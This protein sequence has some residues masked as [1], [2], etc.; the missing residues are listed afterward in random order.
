MDAATA[1]DNGFS[2]GDHVRVLLRGP[3]QEFELVGIF[4]FGDRDDFGAVTFAAFDLQTAQQVFEA[5]GARDRI[6]VQTDPGASTSAVQARL[7]QSL[8]GRFEVLT[9][10]QAIKQV[11]EQVLRPL[12]SST[13]ALL[14]FAAIGVVVGAFVIFNT[15]TILVTQRTRELGLLRAMGATGGQVVRSVVLEAFVVGTV[16]SVIGLGFGILLGAG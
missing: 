12:E 11:G 2:V 1:R 8:R 15:F 14:G 9:P 16:A 10:P 5:P 7:E 13:Y 4:G 3:A 6:Y